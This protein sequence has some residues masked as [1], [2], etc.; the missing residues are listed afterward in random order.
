MPAAAERAAIETP[1]KDKAELVHA[2]EAALAE[3]FGFHR[4]ARR[5]P[6][7]DP[8]P[9]STCSGSSLSARPSKRWLPRTNGAGNFSGL[10]GNVTKAYKALL[11][12]ERAA[13]YL[14]RVASDPYAGG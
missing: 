2:L 12:D 8:W 4:G 14:K 5:R 1:I 3:A 10:A 13:P 9:P 11:P 6:Q 7:R